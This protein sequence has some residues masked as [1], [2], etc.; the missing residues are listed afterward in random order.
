MKEIYKLDVYKLAEELSDMVWH[1]FEE[2]K[3]WLRKLVMRK[4]VAGEEILKHANIVDEF[5]PKLNAVI[6]STK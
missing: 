2:T 3:A 6:R 5:G 1:A 4:I